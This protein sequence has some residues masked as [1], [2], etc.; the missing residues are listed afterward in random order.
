MWRKRKKG[1][2]LRNIDIR[3]FWIKIARA[4]KYPL[5]FRFSNTIF[6][7]IKELKF[8]ILMSVFQAN[9]FLGHGWP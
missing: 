2:Q 9:D 8:G 6:N 4:P 5:Y 3:Y 7:Y 1:V